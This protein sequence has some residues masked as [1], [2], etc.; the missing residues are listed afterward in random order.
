MEAPKGKSVLFKG[1]EHK[2]VFLRTCKGE[3]SSTGYNTH[4]WR[5]DYFFCERCLDEQQ[6]KNEAYSRDTPEWYRGD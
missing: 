6:R 3:N 4:F 2:Y 1:C 5:I